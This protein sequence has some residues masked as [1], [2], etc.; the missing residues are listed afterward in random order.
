MKVLLPWLAVLAVVLLLD[1]M[2]LSFLATAVAVSWLVYCVWTWVRPKS[3][4]RAG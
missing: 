1:A 3:R 4:N 2:H